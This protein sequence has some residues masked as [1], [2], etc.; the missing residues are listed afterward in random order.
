MKLRISVTQKERAV[1]ELMVRGYRPREIVKRL[2]IG[3]QA[4]RHRRQMLL[5][6]LGAENDAQLGALAYQYG[7]VPFDVQN[8]IQDRIDERRDALRPVGQ[9][10][11]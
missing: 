4:F 1:L 7:L 8:D 2:N 10:A 9:G 3:N 6:K 11:Q 5:E